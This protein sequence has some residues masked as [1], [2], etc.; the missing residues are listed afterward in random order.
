MWNWKRKLL[1]IYGNNYSTRDGTCIRD[2]IH[3]SD[4]AQAHVCAL[5]NMIGKKIVKKF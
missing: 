4:V 5:N 2:Y 1:T 3:V